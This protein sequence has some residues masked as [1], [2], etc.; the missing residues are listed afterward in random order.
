MRPSVSICP[1][2][3]IVPRSPHACNARAVTNPP[4]R[5]YS[6]EGYALWGAGRRLFLRGCS[7]GCAGGP[8]LIHDLGDLVEAGFLE[9]TIAA[10]LS[11]DPTQVSRAVALFDEGNTIPFV[12]R[13]RKEVTGSLSEEQLRAI[14]ARAQYL[15][16]LDERKRTVLG[17]IESL[18][19][20][21]ADLR[22]RIQ[23]AQVLQEVEDLYL[24]Y[25]PKRRTRA[26]IARERGLG[27]LAQM[28]LA[29]ETTRGVPE[30]Y[31]AGYVSGEVPTIEDALSG[32][33][34]IV[35]EIVAEESTARAYV[36]Q[37]LTSTGLLVS[38]RARKADD[39]EGTY[40]QY[41]EYTERLAVVPPHRLLAVNRGEREGVLSVTLE[42]DDEAI[43]RALQRRMVRREGAVFTPQF[44][45]AIEDGY[46]RLMRPSIE[47]E[48]RA[49]RTEAAEAHAVEVFGA[50]LRALLLQSPLDAVCVMGV[51]P[52]YRSGCKAAV[53][54][55]TGKHL[56]SATIYPHE[57]QKRWTEA[58]QTLRALI[59]RWGIQVLAV[60]NGTASR[61]TES[62]AAE[63]IAEGAPVSY[64]MVSE[65]GAS[66]YSASEL[67]VA[68]LPQL[69][70]SVRGAVSIARRLQDPLAELVKI[71]AKS[72]GVGLYQHDVDQKKLGEELDAVVESA[73]NYVGVDVNSASPALLQHVAGLSARV[74]KA[75]VARRDECGPFRSRLDLMRVRG[76]GAMT[77]EQAAGFLRIRE[78]D[79]PLDNTFIHPESYP[80]CHRLLALLGVS[81]A[82]R[83]RRQAQVGVTAT[84]PAQVERAWRAIRAQGESTASLAEKLGTGVPTLEDILANLLKPGRDPRD[85]LPAPILR[86][87]VLR[88]EDLRVGMKLKGTVRNVVGFGVFVDIGVKQDGLVHVSELSDRYVRDPLDVVAV[89]NIVD[90]CVLAVDVERG[91]V[92]LSMRT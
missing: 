32:A 21:S 18:G 52:G 81:G 76:L 64:V 72:I 87:D 20:L 59:E 47:R 6:A 29:Q 1:V 71:D 46:H 19:Q 90:V 15:R 42:A 8:Y 63:L 55:Q 84:L 35:A 33:R 58:K 49:A 73:V 10:D 56:A 69:D 48:V 67:A 27:P 62:L 88:I 12:A 92:S 37:V 36:R 57:P 22:K 14:A 86:H 40:R 60:G 68:E 85:D 5:V 2:H 70:V 25:K 82:A 77:F 43:L 44:V 26:A 53:V 16:H 51:D 13:Y 23:A 31:A 7:P 83:T 75:I 9:R 78:G 17:T 38:R 89:G 65:A 4:L 50:N 66:V 80:V 34:D 54:D 24:P 30:R 39:L 91:R 79:D 3:L 61:E 41:Y 74:A 45:A 28:I 11:L